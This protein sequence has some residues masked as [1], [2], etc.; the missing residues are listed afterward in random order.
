[1]FIHMLLLLPT[2]EPAKLVI[3]EYSMKEVKVDKN[4]LDKVLSN[5]F[6]EHKDGIQEKGHIVK[7]NNE[8]EPE[9]VQNSE[10]SEE[11]STNGFVKPTFDTK[12][13]T[14]FKKITN[15]ISGDKFNLRGTNLTSKSEVKMKTT[16]DD[17]FEQDPLYI[18]SKLVVKLLDY[19][20]PK[21]KIPVSMPHKKKKPKLS[22]KNVTEEV[23]K[24]TSK[25]RVR[26]A[27]GEFR[28]STEY[29]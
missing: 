28:T 19:L 1:M 20:P 16:D 27:H 2:V 13:Q 5:L 11:E 12:G 15:R 18:L 6:P 23:E 3:N 8:P 22:K 24:K 17:S 21:Y 29:L 14:R 25:V 9:E 26:L 7:F 4:L 10:H